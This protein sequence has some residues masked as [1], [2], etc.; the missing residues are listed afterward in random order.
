MLLG[1]VNDRL[2]HA[3]EVVALLRRVNRPLKVNL[4]VWNPGP[5]IPYDMPQ[6]HQVIEFQQRL[7]L[8]RNTRLHPPPKRPRHLRRLR[9]VKAHR[10]DTNRSARLAPSH[11]RLR[12]MNIL[13]IT[14]HPER[15]DHWG[16]V[17][18]PAFFAYQADEL[19]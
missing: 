11:V 13:S 17:E 3:D 18:G 16:E 9:P 19:H 2:A 4:I 12:G 7:K 10:P 6:P 1:G 5:G 14:L 8:E 15:S